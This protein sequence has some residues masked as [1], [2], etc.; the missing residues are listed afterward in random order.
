VAFTSVDTAAFQRWADTVGLPMRTLIREIILWRLSDRVTPTL[1]EHLSAVSAA[2]A[3]HRDRLPER[4]RALARRTYEIR[5]QR[6]QAAFVEDIDRFEVFQ[7][8]SGICGICKQPVSLDELSVDHVIPIAR[9]GLHAYS[10]VQAAHGR[11]NSK[12]GARLL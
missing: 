12:K 2:R 10:N 9:G 3:A 5:Q 1:S 8:S 11:C 7:R 6:M 4:V